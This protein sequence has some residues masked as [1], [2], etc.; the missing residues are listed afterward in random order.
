LKNLPPEKISRDDNKLMIE[1]AN[2]YKENP[3]IVQAIVEAGGRV[4]SV[5]VSGSSLE[6][7]YLK[8]VRERE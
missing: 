1:L 5:S 7:A 8:L 2:P 6:D 4:Q 3:S